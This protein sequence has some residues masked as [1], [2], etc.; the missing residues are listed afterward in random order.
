MTEIQLGAT[1]GQEE[2]TLA[3]TYPNIPN[4]SYNFKLTIEIFKQQ[5]GAGQLHNIIKKDLYIPEK[6]VVIKPMQGGQIYKVQCSGTF[7]GV[8]SKKTVFA[9]VSNK[10]S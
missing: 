7:N 1:G 8:L 6:S 2:I 4:L 10:H 3:I 5:I 9:F